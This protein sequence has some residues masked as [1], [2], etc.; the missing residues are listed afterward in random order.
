VAARRWLP[1]LVGGEPKSKLQPVWKDGEVSGWKHDVSGVTKYYDLSGRRTGQDEITIAG[2]MP[3]WEY[4]GLAAGGVRV[5]A[6]G[7]AKGVGALLGGAKSVG[8]T[9]KSAW[10]ALVGGEA[11]K[12]A[13]AVPFFRFPQNPAPIRN[14][15]PNAQVRALK[16]DPNG[17]AQ[18]GV[19]YKW[20]N[21]EGQTV[22]FRIHGPDGTAPAGSNAANGVTY[23]VQVGG[24]YMDATGNLYKRGVHNPQSPY[25]DPDAA[26]ATHIPW[27]GGK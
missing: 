14:I 13:K 15:P 4:A 8:K 16:P 20:V 27:P 18:W 17:G 6:N 25:Y 12:G 9:L 19:E 21:A 26:N 24:R 5:A 22:R 23:R 2:A 10:K 7:A 11:K 3:P 1:I